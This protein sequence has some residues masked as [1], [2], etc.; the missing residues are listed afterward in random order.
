MAFQ[1]RA[2]AGP[3]QAPPGTRVSGRAPA[4]HLPE[5]VAPPGTRVGRSEKPQAYIPYSGP[6]H[7]DGGVG[8]VAVCMVFVGVM[9]VVQPLST[10][11]LVFG[12]LFGLAGLLIGG[13]WIRMWLLWRRAWGNGR[14][15]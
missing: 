5:G 6:P 1:R 13:I 15:R 7:P 2:P 14:W 12:V 3:P 8:M 9:A 10:G 11:G 4:A